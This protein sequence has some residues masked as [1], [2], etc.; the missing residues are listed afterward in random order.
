MVKVLTGFE[1]CACIRATIVA[2]STPPDKKGPER[3][4]GNHANPN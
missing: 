4:V 3:N 1:L 2:E